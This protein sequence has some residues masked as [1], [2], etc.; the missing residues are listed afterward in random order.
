MRFRDTLDRPSSVGERGY[1]HR[2]SV[3]NNKQCPCSEHQ[4]EKLA[5]NLRRVSPSV[6]IYRNESPQNPRPDT[7]GVSVFF[8]DNFRNEL[9]ISAEKYDNVAHVEIT[10]E[11]ID[12]DLATGFV[13]THKASGDVVDT[14]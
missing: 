6:S 7:E 2:V 8:S 3:V 11:F 5:H 1:T 12:C 9:S 10:G 13:I 14:M 4:K